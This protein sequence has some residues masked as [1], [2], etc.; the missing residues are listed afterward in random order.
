MPSVIT[1]NQEIRDF[2]LGIGFEDL[3]IA[4]PETGPFGDRYR[5]WV[6]MG[7]GGE[8]AYMGRDPDRR[9]DPSRVMEGVQSVILVS[10]NY[11]PGNRRRGLLDRPDIGYIS[12]YALDRDYHPVLEERLQVIQEF[13]SERIGRVVAA[14]IYVDTGPLLEKALAHRAGLG[15]IGKHTNLVAEGK[16]SW[17]FLGAMLLDVDLPEDPAAED[18]CGRCTRCIDVCPTGAIVEP[19]V[20]DARRCISYLTIEL[21]GAIPE[22]LRPLIGNRIFGCDDCQW[23][24]PWNR[25]AQAAT[26]TAFIPKEEL[27]A[28]RLID[29]MALDEEGFRRLFQGSPVKRIKRKGLLRNVAVALGNV[30]SEESIPVLRK[31]AESDP[32]PLVREHSA[33]ALERIVQ[34]RQGGDL[35]S[36]AMN[37]EDRIS[38]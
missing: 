8:M 17:Y 20:L 6:S 14:R 32:E 12:N 18:R 19:Y 28:P 37:E 35:L 15:W 22:D 1:L 27:D 16:G 31:A 33:W 24:C 29:L 23:V 11:F 7:Y 2:G 3:R 36:P 38:P 10:M 13:I 25:F 4:R 9:A 5:E 21:K 34:R 30:G 26:E